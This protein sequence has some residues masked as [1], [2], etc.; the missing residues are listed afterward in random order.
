VP[1][2]PE[3]VGRRLT[4]LC[5]ELADGA[6]PAGEFLDN[7]DRSDRRKL[8]VLFELM[9]EQGQIYNPEKFKKLGGSDEIFEFKSHQ[10]RI[11]CIFGRK[12]T[13]VLLFGLRKKSDRYKGKEINRAEQY[14]QWY[15]SQGG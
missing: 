13:I 7:L 3:F 12:Q 15:L 5:L 9:G 4:V 10:I 6:C 11:P 14:R 8:D 2:Q 1:R